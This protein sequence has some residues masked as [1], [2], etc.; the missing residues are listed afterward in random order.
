VFAYA[1]D[2]LQLDGDDLWPKPLA[3]RKAALEKLLAKAK[4]GVHYSEHIDGAGETIFAHAFRMKLEGIVS[5]RLDF[6]LSIRPGK[7]RDQGQEL[8]GTGVHAS[9]RRHLVTPALFVGVPAANA[10]QACAGVTNGLIPRLYL[11][12]PVVKNPLHLGFSLQPSQTSTYAF[13]QSEMD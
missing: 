5:K 11:G 12:R 8:A 3:D 2:L 4:P 1:F 9:D 7:D 6:P 10:S 13:F